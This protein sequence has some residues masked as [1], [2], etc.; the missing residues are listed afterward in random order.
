M[1]G[2][3]VSMITELKGQIFFPSIS[4]QA[5][6]CLFV[7]KQMGFVK[8]SSLQLGIPHTQTQLSIKFE[9]KTL[10]GS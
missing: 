9:I 2:S 7:F 10:T 6:N 3:N 5:E 1:V 4:S 8:L